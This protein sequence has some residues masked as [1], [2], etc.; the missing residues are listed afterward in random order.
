[1]ESITKEEFTAMLPK[2]LRGNLTEGVMQEIEKVVSDPE[3]AIHFRNN[4][5]SYTSVLEDGKF[6][7]Q[8]YVQAT[9]F[10]THKLLGSSDKQAYQKT[11]PDRYKNLVDAD[12]SDKEMSAYFSAYKKTKLVTSI[13]AQSMIP[14]HVANMDVHQKAIN[15]LA[16]LMV[17]AKSEKVQADA[18]TALLVN[19]R[20]PEVKKVEL[21][22][23]MKDNGIADLER[24]ITQLA[25]KQQE[26]I[27]LGMTTAKDTA[28]QKL[29]IENEPM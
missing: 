23:G 10:V 20:P 28:N 25:A 2:G 19:L 21:A 17:T 26:L 13:L 22:V 3:Y 4:L 24:T 9:K 5:V 16:T 7:L 29:V 12:R 15:H 27:S 18:A 14:I 11:F 1:M 8:D 6:K